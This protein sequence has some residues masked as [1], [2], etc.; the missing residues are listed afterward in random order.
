MSVLDLCRNARSQW[1]AFSRMVW[2][3]DSRQLTQATL[4]RLTGELARRYARLLSRRRRIESVRARLT[5]LERRSPLRASLVRNLL[6]DLE[7]AYARRRQVFA[8]RKK[9]HKALLRGQVVACPAPTDAEP[10]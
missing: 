2:P 9:L 4:E 10:T 5:R 6:T 1:I 3:E 8:R 7:D